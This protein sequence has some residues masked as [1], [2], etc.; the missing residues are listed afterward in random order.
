MSTLLG[1]LWAKRNNLKV[2][3]LESGLT[4]SDV[5]N[6]FPEEIIRRIVS[7]AER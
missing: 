7:K 6:P 5:F 1:M 4:S 3:H 2:L